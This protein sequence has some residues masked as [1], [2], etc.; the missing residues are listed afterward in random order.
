M[1]LLLQLHN[2][3]LG[4]EAARDFSVPFANDA[5]MLFAALMALRQVHQGQA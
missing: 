3:A 5:K 1:E 4:L 2:K